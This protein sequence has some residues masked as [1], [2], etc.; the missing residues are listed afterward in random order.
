[1][2][3]PRVIVL[4]FHAKEWHLPWW[5]PGLYPIFPSEGR[6]W[7]LDGYRKHPVLSVKRTHFMTTP[8]LAVTAHAAQGRTAAA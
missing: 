3:L 4:D 5:G 8:A 2:H 1:M 7:F 6:K